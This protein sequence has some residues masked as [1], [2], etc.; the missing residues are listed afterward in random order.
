MT[1]IE[2]SKFIRDMTREGENMI[3]N[4]QAHDLKWQEHQRQSCHSDY[5]ETS[6]SCDM[7]NSL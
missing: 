1:L 3:M 6:S 7:Y 2:T 4:D 5:F